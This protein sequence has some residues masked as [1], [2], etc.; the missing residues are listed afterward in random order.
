[1]S[2]VR[3]IARSTV[4]ILLGSQVLFWGLAPVAFAATPVPARE[5]LSA[6]RAP[7]G[8]PETE[9]IHRLDAAR[10]AAWRRVPHELGERTG[11]PLVSGR[12]APLLARAASGRIARTRA[13]TG[14]PD[15]VRVLALRIDFDQD[16]L[17]PLTTTPDG[18]F[19][20]RN[21]DSLGLFIDPPPHNRSFFQAHLEALARY[22]KW[23]SYGNLVITSDV[24]PQAEDA[25]YRLHDTGS[26]GPWTLGQ[27]SFNE[28]QRFFKD[29]VTVADRTDSIPFGDFDVVVVFHAGSDFQ[30]DVKGDSPRDIPTFTI[31]LN[32]SVP[33]NGGA[34]A[35]RGG[36][37]LP[38]T[39]SQDGL[40]GAINGTFA[41]EFG[42]TQGLVDLYDIETFL[43]AVGVWS[44]MDSA[45]LLGTTVQDPKTC[46]LVDASGILPAS[47]DPWSKDLLWP[48]RLKFVDPGRAL[49]D[50]LR[51]TELSDSILYVPLG[52][53]EYYLIENRA[54]DL[55]GDGTV[56]LDRDSTSGVVLGPGLATPS[57]PRCGRPAST[58]IP[59]DSLGDKEYDFLLP[60]LGGILVWHIDNSVIY[61]RYMP[62][63]G[64]INTNPA[65]HGVKVV[66]ADGIE[67]LGD[68]NSAYLFGSPF[69][70]Y[71]VGNHTDLGPAT[72]PS[73]TTNDGGVTGIT[74]QVTSRPGVEMI[75]AFKETTRVPGW[76]V[77]TTVQ[78]KGTAPTYGSLLGDGNRNVVT[79]ADSLVFAWMSDGE[80]F[81]SS[82]T[83]G[84]LVALPARA[85]LPVLFADSLYHRGP[86]IGRS[87]AVVVTALDGNIYAYRPQTRGDTTSVLLPGWPPALTDSTGATPTTA[88]TSPVLGPEGAVLVGAADGTVYSISPTDTT[89]FLPSVFQVAPPLEVEGTPLVEPVTG[90][91]AVGRFT[92]AGGYEVAYAT[93]S[94]W[95]RVVQQFGKYTPGGRF[96][97][98]WHVRGG[99][100]FAPYLAGADMDRGPDGNLELIVC[101]PA[102]NTIHCYDLAG[103]ELPGWPVSTAASL[104]GP[105]AVGDLD[106]D[107]Y[108]EV[109]ATD[110][111]GL[112]HRWNRNGVEPLGW[113]VS[114]VDHFGPYAVGGKGSPLVADVDGDGRPEVIVGLNNGLLVALGA[115]GRTKPGWP[116]ALQGGASSTPLLL[117]M[118]DA[119]FPPDPPG[120]PWTHL[121]IGGDDD[122]GVNAFQIGAVADTAFF[123]R[124]A[125]SAR[126]PWSEAGGNRR[127]TSVLESTYQG[128]VSLAARLLKPGSVYCYPN[129][130]KGTDRTEIGLAYALGAAATRVDIR[131]FDAS[132]AEVARQQGPTLPIENVARIPVRRLAS[133]VYLVRL[134]ATG[135]GTSET[136]FSKFAIVR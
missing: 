77:A 30:T 31:S 44:N 37:V 94:G 55:N 63:D 84:R 96:D 112:V 4:R 5:P 47:L 127:H 111:S 64:G 45:Y 69:D 93:Q 117:S 53:E 24:W 108:P 42:H 20:L 8:S 33:V 92:G 78:Q 124:D 82:R 66:E 41:H 115:D 74:M 68:P 61:G 135:T 60:G 109:F 100:S 65:R 79:A 1:M 21:G 99:S 19:D 32:D 39:E 86:S 123:G 130:L 51:A 98:A 35:I 29:A 14:A 50:T 56:Y 76:P 13:F 49:V 10:L 58:G 122:D 52:N 54:V 106:G 128:P 70:P 16:S 18:K 90:T 36:M 119:L 15:T 7:A 6:A 102:A 103:H 28:A 9:R 71:F 27:E 83:D 72:S 88:T 34:V 2:S 125:V 75:V 80:S 89:A 12:R 48:G 131:I 107:G 59:G 134:E 11:R 81:Y 101:D 97:V 95:V 118:N 132:G 22:W 26:Y 17:G 87:A 120:G 129:P 91:M 133:G 73:S 104:P 57:P 116:L 23:A 38:E 46:Q 110:A 113:P 85:R 114:M 40:Y 3:G 62:S 136:V 105:I 121:V 67:D 43:P 25:S 126:T